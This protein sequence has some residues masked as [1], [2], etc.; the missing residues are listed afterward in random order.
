MPSRWRTT[1]IARGFFNKPENG[2]ERKTKEKEGGAELGLN[3]II[4]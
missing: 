3:L 2:K 1:K 4:C